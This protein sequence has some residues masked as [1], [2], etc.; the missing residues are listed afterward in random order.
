MKIITSFKQFLNESASII[1]GY[2]KPKNKL[3][4][5]QWAKWLDMLKEV[6]TECE[7]I[8]TTATELQKEYNYNLHGRDHRAEAYEFDVKMHHI[9]EIDS[10]ELRAK[11]FDGSE[12][13]LNQ[14]WVDFVARQVEYFVEDLQDHYKIDWI[15]DY[16]QV[17][18]SGGWL[19]LE[20]EPS[21]WSESEV[22]YTADMFEEDFNYQSEEL[23]EY[24]DETETFSADMKELKKTYRNVMNAVNGYK[25][26][27][28]KHSEELATIRK[29]IP[30]VQAGMGKAFK[31]QLDGNA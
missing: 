18:R 1:Q 10:E 29:Q 23:V 20:L 14:A 13:E 28:D 12:D 11:Y 31:D 26:G 16:Y 22:E 27:L 15:K 3:G 17:G 24:D 9:P 6:E 30:I 25:K 8:R 19:V 21:T 7:Y 5:K 2:P 4:Q